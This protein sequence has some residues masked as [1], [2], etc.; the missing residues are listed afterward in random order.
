[1]KVSQAFLVALVF[2]MSLSGCGPVANKLAEPGPLSAKVSERNTRIHRDSAPGDS[3]EL[4]HPA[5]TGQCEDGRH[6]TTR[7]RPESKKTDR[8][9]RPSD[10]TAYGIQGYALLAELG[11]R[12]SEWK[13]YCAAS[14]T[15]QAPGSDDA[16]VVEGSQEGT[17]F[18]EDRLDGSGNY[19]TA[20]MTRHPERY[21]DCKRVD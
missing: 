21:Y 7:N 1:M 6:A 8:P 9:F 4:K 10:C 17:W 19:G 14:Q 5:G 15:E 13:A 2:A 11:H 18:C 12:M 16:V 3:C 20:E